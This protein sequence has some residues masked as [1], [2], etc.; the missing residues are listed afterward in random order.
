M[1]CFLPGDLEGIRSKIRDLFGG[2]EGSRFD[3]LIQSANAEGRGGCGFWSLVLWVE[4]LVFVC[5][6]PVHLATFPVSLLLALGGSLTTSAQEDISDSELRSRGVSTRRVFAFWTLWAGFDAVL[7]AFLALLTLSPV[8]L[9]CI[10]F[11]RLLQ[12]AAR[13]L[14]CPRGDS[15]REE[16]RR[17][18]GAVKG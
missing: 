8:I 12:P 6:L 10:P 7:P 17:R 1:L 9:L 5:L 16:P 13:R 3:C 18:V 11:I 4:T 15:P 14:C 2:D